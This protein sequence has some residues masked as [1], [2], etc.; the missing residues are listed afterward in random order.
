MGQ[1]GG[2]ELGST[3]HRGRADG[4]VAAVD[5]DSFGGAPAMTMDQRKGGWGGGRRWCARGR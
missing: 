3:A 2:S 5:S 4:A 1:I